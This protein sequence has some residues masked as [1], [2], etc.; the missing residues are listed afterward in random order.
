MARWVRWSYHIISC[1]S[2]QFHL[3]VLWVTRIHLIDWHANRLQVNFT[4]ESMRTFV[5]VSLCTKRCWSLFFIPRILHHC[6]VWPVKLSFTRETFPSL[7]ALFTS[8]SLLL[9]VWVSVCMMQM[10]YHWKET[11]EEKWK[12][13]RVHVN[14]HSWARE[15]V[16]EGKKGGGGGGGRKEEEKL[17]A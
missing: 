12:Y 17:T 4:I 15:A 13:R 6:S 1:A 8:E 5:R 16:K 7:F 10:R 2:F 9:C 14:V 3:T 11:E